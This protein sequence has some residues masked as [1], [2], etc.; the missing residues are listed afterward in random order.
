M[1]HGQ[2]RPEN[3]QRTQVLGDYGCRV[4][5]TALFCPPLIS[6]ALISGPAASALVEELFFKKVVDSNMGNEY[7]CT[8][9]VC[10]WGR[11]CGVF[12]SIL[13]R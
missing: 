7:I 2:F 8:L 13:M 10:F 12:L 3:L 6:F 9:R 5:V 11:G 4:C 1:L